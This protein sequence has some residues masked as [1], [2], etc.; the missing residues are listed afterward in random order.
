LPGAM[1]GVEVS[2]FRVIHRAKRNFVIREIVC[3]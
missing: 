2:L 1:I 3:A